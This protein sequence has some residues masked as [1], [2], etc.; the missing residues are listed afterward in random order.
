MCRSKTMCVLVCLHVMLWESFTC[1]F[2]AVH[3]AVLQFIFF[4]NFMDF[5]KR[6]RKAETQLKNTIIISY[7]SV[8]SINCLLCPFRD[9]DIRCNKNF[10]RKFLSCMNGALHCNEHVGG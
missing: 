9:K 10:T 6:D 2:V 8:S 7:L 3:K 5:L 4:Q 1:A